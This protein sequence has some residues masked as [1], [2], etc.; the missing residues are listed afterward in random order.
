MRGKNKVPVGAIVVERGPVEIFLISLYCLLYLILGMVYRVGLMPK[1]NTASTTE[2]L[3]LVDFRKES[4]SVKTSLHDRDR[5]E[6]I[7]LDLISQLQVLATGAVPNDTITWG[8]ENAL[9]YAESPIRAVAESAISAHSKVR[10]ELSLFDVRVGVYDLGNLSYTTE[11]REF[12]DADGETYY[13]CA[14]TGMSVESWRSPY[15]NT[16]SREEALEYYNKCSA[17]INSVVSQV[18]AA[19]SSD[20]EPLSDAK[21]LKWVHDWLIKNADYAYDET[22]YSETT[23]H[24]CNEYGALVDG[25]AV[26]QGY[27]HA[28]K[29][30]VD[31][32]AR[33]TGADIECEEAT[34][35]THSWA[36]VKLDGEWYNVD[37]TWDECNSSPEYISEKY[38]L[39]S[40]DVVSDDAHQNH[41]SVSSVKATNKQYEGKDWGKL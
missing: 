30:I 18:V 20:G 39:V 14:A 38:F 6:T 33:Q 12:T 2:P 37:V 32:L 3:S 22:I 5:A 7:R 28:F 17:Q 9:F 11:T 24:L 21:K 19:R 41:S 29:A 35:R 31:E 40:D 8:F 15:G 27:A 25:E 10:A 23:R 1:P 26:C 36:R 13:R 34:T 16:C 4:E